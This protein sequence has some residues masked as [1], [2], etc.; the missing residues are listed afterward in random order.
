MKKQSLKELT[1]SVLGVKSKKCTK[2]G[3]RKKLTSNNFYFDKRHK[4]GFHS[5]CKKCY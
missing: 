3:K 1:N 5:A 2:C 4:D